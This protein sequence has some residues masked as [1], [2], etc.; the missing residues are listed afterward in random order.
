MLIDCHLHLTIGGYLSFSLLPFTLWDGLLFEQKHLPV[1]ERFRLYNGITNLARTPGGIMELPW[2]IQQHYDNVKIIPSTWDIFRGELS[3]PF[4]AQNCVN[5]KK[6]Q[7]MWHSF[8]KWRLS[9]IRQHLFGLFIV[10]EWV[11]SMRPYTTCCPKTV[12]PL[13][14]FQLWLK[15]FLTSFS[16]ATENHK[17]PNLNLNPT[18][19]WASELIHSPPKRCA[20]EECECLR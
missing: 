14:T 16:A 20:R 6:C 4:Y 17:G 9:E 8:W 19:T 1:R 18:W 5:S 2:A 11:N 15:T 3:I 10:R 12:Q 7:E 13:N